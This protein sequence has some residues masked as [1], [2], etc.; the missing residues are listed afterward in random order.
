MPGNLKKTDPRLYA[1]IQREKRRQKETLNLIA[2]ESYAPAGTLEALGSVLSNKYS[3]GYPAKRYYPGTAP[4]D[5]LEE[6]ARQRALKLFSLSPDAWRANAQAY[7]G[8]IANV[9]IYQAILK[10]GDRILAMD[11]AAGGHLSHGS[12]A[13]MSGSLYEI[14]R[15]GVDGGYEIDYEALGRQAAM[16]KPRLIISGASAYP[17]AIDFAR[18]G[19]M[20]RKAGAYHLADISHYAGLVAAGQYPS[21]FASSDIVMATTHKSLLGARGALI[22][23]SCD[24]PAAAAQ[25]IFLPDAIDRA[26]FPGLQGGPHNNA[27]AGI[28]HGLL[29]SLQKKGYFRQVVRNARALEAALARE[30]AQ[31]VGKTAS[32]MAL[33]RCADLGLQGDEAQGALEDVG[34]LANG[35]MLAGDKSASH[36]SGVRFGT[37]AVTLRGMKEP[38][39]RI[40][41]SLIMDALLARRPSRDVARDARALCRQFPAIL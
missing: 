11:L 5:E 16:L 30:G 20:A 36:P 31:I 24:S 34:I 6:L 22:F 14:H 28:A 2:S 29:Q 37:Y 1:L 4:Y 35:N 17:G 26:V 10:P 15:Y 21:P 19:A 7:S 23:S 27:I 13:H 9:A 41:A 8:A 25:G 33:M 18:I 3:E 12:R 39:M 38:Q 32:H 40:I